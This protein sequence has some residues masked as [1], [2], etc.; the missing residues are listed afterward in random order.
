VL[1]EKSTMSERCINCK[2]SI[3]SERSNTAANAIEW[4]A[5]KRYPTETKHRTDDWCG[6]WKKELTNV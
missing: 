2:H 3:V 6:E 1:K 5:C 4:M